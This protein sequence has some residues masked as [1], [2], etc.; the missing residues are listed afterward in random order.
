MSQTDTPRSQ[1]AAGLRTALPFLASAFPLGVIGGMLGMASGLSAAHTMAL[2][3][4]LNSGTAQFLATRLLQEHASIT[5]ILL[6][7]LVLSLRMVVYGLA[8]RPHARGF[9]AGWRLVLGFGLIDAV[10]FAV[11][12]RLKQP[13]NAKHWRW[14]FVGVSGAM[15]AGWLLATAV[16]IGLGTALPETMLKGLDFPLVAMFGAMLASTLGDRKTY[17]VMAVTA[18]LA[19]LTNGMPY[20]V[21]LL[22]A[23]LAGASFGAVLDWLQQGQTVAANVEG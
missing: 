15:Y 11:I 3:A 2:S 16:G 12:E 8:L 23:A 19:V 21:G 17:A 4:I 1:L 14:F 18:V 5:V 22:V 6:T 13:A 20:H 7:I 10:F 9:P